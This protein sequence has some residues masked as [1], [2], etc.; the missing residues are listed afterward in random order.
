M[1]HFIHFDERLRCATRY[2]LLWVVVACF[3]TGVAQAAPLSWGSTHTAVYV[4]P[5]NP[6]SNSGGFDLKAGA[7]ASQASG[8]DV[9]M[10]PGYES[11]WGQ[12]VVVLDESLETATTE[13][14]NNYRSS[15]YLITGKVYL[16]VMRDGTRAKVRIDTITPSRVYFSYRLQ[17][18]VTQPTNTVT[19]LITCDRAPYPGGVSCGQPE[20][21]GQLFTE[22]EINYIFRQN[23]ACDLLNNDFDIYWCGTNSALASDPGFLIAYRFTDGTVSRIVY[24]R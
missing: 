6:T 7:M 12:G 15:E 4:V 10:N 24:L 16:V 18:S 5:S 14:P 9:F 20:S 2:L 3:F 22:T 21:L 17:A 8:S 1:L 11:I 13:D 23:L 19:Y